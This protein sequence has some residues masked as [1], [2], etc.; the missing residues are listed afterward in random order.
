[1]NERQHNMILEKTHASGTEEW[2]CP[3]CGRILLVSWKPRFMKIVLKPGD[4]YAI[5]S[6]GKGGLQMGTARVATI[7]DEVLQRDFEIPVEEMWLAPWMEWM[8]QVDFD[9]LWDE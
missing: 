4:E 8:D 7:D 6:G 2:Y 3:T 1:M 9:S 5:H